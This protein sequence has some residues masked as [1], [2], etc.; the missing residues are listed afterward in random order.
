[1]NPL[2]KRIIALVVGVVVGGLVVGGAEALG[3]S[4]YPPPP[5][6]NVK[7][8]EDL[9][10]L[11]EV[12]P[13]QAK[14]MVVV[15]WFLGAFVGA[16]TAI[17]IGG[18]NVLGLWVGAIFAGLSIMTVMSIPHP[19]WMTACAIVLPFVAAWLAIKVSKRA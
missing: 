14:I 7:D 18:E 9:K 19:L 3:H 15:A 5:D 10:G 1:M 13:I 2:L 16:W 17:R 6:I 12:V 11:M 8:P 4:I